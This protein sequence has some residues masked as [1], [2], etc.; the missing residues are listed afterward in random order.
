[1][2]VLQTNGTG[3]GAGG[4]NGSNLPT[5]RDKLAVEVVVLEDR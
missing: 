1:M 4:P 5:P 2:V 3:P